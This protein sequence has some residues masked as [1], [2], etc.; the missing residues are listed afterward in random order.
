MIYEFYAP[1]L[2]LEQ[3]KLNI[4]V[5]G[6][7]IGLSELLAYPGAVYVISR[8]KRRITA[9][10]SFAVTY[11]CSMILIFVWKQGGEGDEKP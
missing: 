6:L 8:Y 2:M 9:Y 7:I 11:V 4:F 3:F 10:V 5:N 1:A